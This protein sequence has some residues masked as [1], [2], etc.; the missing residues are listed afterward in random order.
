MTFRTTKD[1][2]ER[3]ASEVF[4]PFTTMENYKKEHPECV[5]MVWG[6][7]IVYIEKSG[8]QK[9]I[10]IAPSNKIL[11]N[12]IRAIKTYNNEVNIGRNKV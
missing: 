1:Q 11:L 9:E 12:K 10:I 4:Q 8:G 6:T 5:Y 3:E 2:L 7:N